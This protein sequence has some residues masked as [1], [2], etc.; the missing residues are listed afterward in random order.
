MITKEVALKHY[1]N[2]RMSGVY[3][4]HCENIDRSSFIVHVSLFLF[5]CLRVHP[6]E[7]SNRFVPNSWEADESSQSAGLKQSFLSRSIVITSFQFSDKRITRSDCVLHNRWYRILHGIST[8]FE[9]M[10]YLLYYW[11]FRRGVIV[12]FLL[13]CMLQDRF[14]RKTVS[15]QPITAKLQPLSK[16]VPVPPEFG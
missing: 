10:Q 1:T 8:I 2:C 6:I 4:A 7:L 12:S 3:P 13:C 14:H 15:S 5:Y 16:F 9:K 11:D